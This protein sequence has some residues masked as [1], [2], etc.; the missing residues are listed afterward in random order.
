MPKKRGPATAGRRR[1]DATYYHNYILR[2]DELPP[3]G[4]RGM[5]SPY[6]TGRQAHHDEH[7]FIVTHQTYELWFKQM[8]EDI[9]RPE[10][11]LAGCLRHGD[12]HEAVRLLRR[13]TK[14]TQILTD[15]YRV[16]ETLAP[17]DFL[18]FRDVLRPSSGYDSAQWRALELMGGLR[19]DGSYL[20]HLVGEVPARGAGP[21]SLAP[22]VAAARRAAERGRPAPLRGYSLVRKMAAA[23]DVNGLALVERAV[24]K[25]SLRE[26]AYQAVQRAD[27]RGPTRSR[28]EERAWM[29]ARAAEFAAETDIARAEGR[30]HDISVDPPT[31]ADIER[32]VVALYRRHTE[33]AKR[34]LEERALFD[35][36]EALVEFDEAMRNLR[37]V[38]IHMVL[39]VIGG[40]EGTGGSTGARYLRTTLDYCFFP[41][42]WRARDQMEGP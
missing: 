20:L 25:P 8:I 16:I 7:L 4:L 5:Q 24:E 26:L 33:G 27:I 42:L 17:S 41:L 31:A 34:G 15:Q 39:R 3:L 30:P 10:T 23:R 21:A 1:P 38:H 14:I 32:R 6:G 40:K 19:E 22:R 11:G 12:L 2:E 13:L 37:S 29:K 36:V 18:V 9:T 28:L 35:L